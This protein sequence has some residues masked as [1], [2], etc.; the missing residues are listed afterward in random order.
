MTVRA[1]LLD[2]TPAVNGNRTKLEAFSPRPDGH[3]SARN[4]H[5]IKAYFRL[6]LEA[7]SQIAYVY[8]PWVERVYGSNDD[9]LMCS[10]DPR[11]Q[12]PGL[13]LYLAFDISSNHI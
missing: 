4:V 13:D 12:I 2:N 5:R 11:H 6:S 8:R 3:K 7:S 1:A 10:V 9:G